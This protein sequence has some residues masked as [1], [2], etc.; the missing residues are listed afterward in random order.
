VETVRRRGRSYEYVDKERTR[1]RSAIARAGFDQNLCD[2]FQFRGR[3][4]S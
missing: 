3:Y 1:F 4:G 2:V